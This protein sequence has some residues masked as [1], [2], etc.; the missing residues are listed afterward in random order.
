MFAHT[1]RTEVAGSV[2]VS[3]PGGVWTVG[4][5]SLDAELSRRMGA[6]V[7]VTPEVGVDHQDAGSVSLV[8]SATLAWCARR[9]GV[10]ADPRRLRVN[11][12]IETDEPFV[13][14][15]W[16]GHTLQVGEVELQ[17]VARIE[18]CRMI[19]VDQDGA[20]SRGRWLKP[21]ADE[22]DL[23]LAVY[24]DVARPGTIAVGAPVVVGA[25]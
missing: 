21:L 17:V 7:A 8:G 23:M 2:T 1:A 18:R 15:T 20:R 22:R 25:D 14:E 10:D 16:S 12:V 24:A 5:A 19:D 9:F 13:E 6:Q 4:D 3:G 11:V